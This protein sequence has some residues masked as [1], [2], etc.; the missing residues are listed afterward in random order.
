MI[1]TDRQSNVYTEGRNAMK[2]KSIDILFCTHFSPKSV[3]LPFLPT[4]KRF[5][6]KTP[7]F[8]NS[9][10]QSKVLLTMALR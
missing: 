6:S 5:F 9:A 10:T 8:F 2:I 7:G 3:P 4:R 1:K